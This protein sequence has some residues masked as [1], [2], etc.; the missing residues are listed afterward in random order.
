MYECA[1]VSM[2]TV[3]SDVKFYIRVKI[4]PRVH[5]ES[6]FISLVIDKLND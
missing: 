5:I 6:L 1:I 3:W 2:K 4:A